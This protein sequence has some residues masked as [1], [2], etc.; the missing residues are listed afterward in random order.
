MEKLHSLELYLMMR[1]PRFSAQMAGD[2]TESVIVI[3][4]ASIASLLDSRPTE[5]AQITGLT[6]SDEIRFAQYNA[7][8][9]VGDKRTLFAQKLNHHGIHIATVQEARHTKS[10]IWQI[11]SH[12]IASSRRLGT[13]FGCEIWLQYSAERVLYSSPKDS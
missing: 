11:E 3:D 2:P 10:G 9:L 6:S 4:A 12:Y 5:P 13:S 8:S 1:N 7:Q